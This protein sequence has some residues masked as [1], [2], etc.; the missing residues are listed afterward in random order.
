MVHIGAS[1]GLTSDELR[2]DKEAVLEVVSKAGLVIACVSDELK[3]DL[4]V[5]MAA[6]EQDCTALMF[7][8]NKNILGNRDIMLTAVKQ[9]GTCLELATNEIRGDKEIVKIA[10]ASDPSV[11]E[12]I[13]I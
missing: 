12:I 13:G 9:K 5:V 7:I 4:E 3:N 11:F 2:S 6:V 1:L 10:L 8:N